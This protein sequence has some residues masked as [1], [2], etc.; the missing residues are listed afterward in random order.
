M[1]GLVSTTHQ[2]ISYQMG[3]QASTSTCSVG[4]EGIKDIYLKKDPSDARRV[5]CLYEASYTEHPVHLESGNLYFKNREVTKVSQFLAESKKTI[6]YLQ[7][8]ANRKHRPL[9][10]VSLK[11]KG[12]NK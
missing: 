11:T 2:Y 10:I 12:L 6:I 7:H 9:T 8:V 5:H 1:I 4:W 3:Q